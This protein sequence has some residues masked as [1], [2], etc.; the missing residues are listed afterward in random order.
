MR[1]TQVGLSQTGTEEVFRISAIIPNPF[2]YVADTPDNLGW[3]SNPGFDPCDVEVIPGVARACTVF[4]KRLRMASAITV[5][6]VKPTTLF[7][8]APTFVESMMVNCTLRCSLGRKVKRDASHEVTNSVTD[9]RAS[10]I[11]E[12]HR[13]DREVQQNP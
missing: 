10:S 2:W 1:V 12:L 9:G 13:T 7:R 11:A 4:T 3:I 6:R 5:I 8:A